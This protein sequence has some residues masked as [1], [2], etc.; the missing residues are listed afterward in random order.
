MAKAHIYLAAG[1]N[2]EATDTFASWIDTTNSLVYDMGTVVLTSV[3]QP[4][5]NVTV[6]GY[7][8]GNAH[9]EG[10]F[11]ANTVVVSNGLRGGSVSTGGDLTIVSNTIFS[12]SPLVRISANTDNFTVNS[13]NTTFTSNV[14]IDSTKTVL[15]SAAN[16]T[17]NAGQLFVRTSS[18]FTGTRVDI[19]GTTFDVTSN[20]IVTA[21]SLNANVD[22]IT[23]GFNAS[24][25]LVV[26]SLADFNSNTNIDGI[27]TVTANAAFTGSNTTV[28]ALEA[29]DEI[30]LKG[31]S[32]RTIKTQS[33][34]STLYSLNLSLANTSATVTPV[35]VSSTALL[36]GLTTTYDVGSSSTRWNKTWTK[37]L[38]VANTVIVTNQ[39][40]VSG[41]AAFNG[42]NTTVTALEATDEIRL[43]GASKTLKVQSTTGTQPVL[44]LSLANTT[45]TVTPL[46]ANSTAVSPGANAIYDL[47]TDLMRWDTAF[48]KDLD[49]ANSV[50]I[51]VDAEVDRDMIIRRDLYVYGAS[52]FS[53]N[54]TLTLSSSDVQDL[55]VSNTVS[56]LGGAGFDTDVLPTANVTFALGSTTR[57]W[58]QV[59][60]NNVTANTVTATTVTAALSGNATTATTLQTARTINGVSFNGSANITVTANTNNT[61]TRGAYLTGSN[62]NG[63]AATTWDV[64]ATDVATASKVVARDASGNFAAN[65]ITAALVGNASTATT[66]QTA[67][68]INGVS[69]NGSANITVTANTNNTLTRGTYL[70]GSN[71]NGSAATTWA[72]DAT[73]AATASKVVARDASGNF[74]ANTITADLVGNATTSTTL[75][76][77]RA[78]NGVNFDGSA[79]ITITANTPNTLTRGTYLTGSN[80]NGGAAT[81]WAVDATTTSTAGKVVARDASQNFA[82]NTITADLVGNAATATTLATARTIN[83]VSFNGS[84]NITVTANTNQAHT[85]GAYLTGSNFNGSAAV[86]WDVDATNLATAGKVVARDASGNF[87]ANTITASSFA[88]I[89]SAIT[90]INGTNITSGTVADARIAT[91]IVRTS[92]SITAGDGLSGG[93]DLSADI[94]FAVDSTVIRTT[95]NQT[96]S[97]TKTFPTLRYSGTALPDTT[98]V[99]N[100]GSSTL[101]FAT[102]FATTLNGTATTAQYA[103]LAENY[104]ADQDYEVG[105]VIAVGGSA[106]VTAADVNNAH[107][108]LGVVSEKPAYLMNNDLEGGTAIALKGRVPVKVIGG[109]KKGDRLAPSTTPGYAQV[110]NSRSAWSFAIALEDGS[111]MVEA[112]IL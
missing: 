112:V 78:I 4:Q 60:A 31:T 14:A 68:T 18:E 67:R 89:G 12:E 111:L 28:T 103:D 62:F 23:L 99:Y 83:G 57:R 19:D 102:V 70:T 10:I 94:S 55:N 30:R 36:P 108:V 101:R 7:T 15:I 50:N 54:V 13:N 27:L 65:T 46:V 107:A 22:V 9:L 34:N 100:L 52:Y 20:T 41:N 42:A 80:F 21:A 81:T 1:A 73:D 56:L 75:A 44:N 45:V 32:A 97:G 63:S 61:L 74:A 58:N 11:S 8:T 35:V 25:S 72:V 53:S 85:A 6:G 93:G 43:K 26:N 29:T 104:L 51:Q 71:F 16:T 49:V 84:A 69:F 40:T 98:N 87:A 24:D 96:L 82:A 48:V 105:T 3:T 33:T 2:V 95:G 92:R 39:I 37:D 5:P 47:G 88:G 90:N 91:T 79:A 106:E 17:I 86:T 109:C 59:F 76:T 64:D 66:L 77:A 110:D 38:D